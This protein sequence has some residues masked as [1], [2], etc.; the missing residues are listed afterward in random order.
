MVR[1]FDAATGAG[2]G[3]YELLNA[4]AGCGSLNPY[5]LTD[6]EYAANATAPHTVCQQDIT[7][8]YSQVLPEQQRWGISGRFTK[9]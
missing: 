9:I 8:D 6:A 1:P 4:A 2:A 7:H 5:T 3:R